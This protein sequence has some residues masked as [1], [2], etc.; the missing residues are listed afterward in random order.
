MGSTR[1]HRGSP[2]GWT[3]EARAKQGSGPSWRPWQR[4]SGSIAAEESWTPETAF[5]LSLVQRLSG[6]LDDAPI[7]ATGAGH[8][9]G[10]LS[11]AGVSAAM[12]FVRNPTGVSH[13][14]AEFVEREDCHRGVEALARVT[15]ELA[16]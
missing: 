14:P 5:D 1:F 7:L 16:R 15:E 12:L 10:I 6:L 2:P 11:A 4:Q 8:D 3:R 13:S 9:A